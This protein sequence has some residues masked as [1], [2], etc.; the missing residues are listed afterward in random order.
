MV[1]ADRRGD[2]GGITRA[3]LRAPLV[4]RTVQTAP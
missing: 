2:D 4:A 3:H 1:L